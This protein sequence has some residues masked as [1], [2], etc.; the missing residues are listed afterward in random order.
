M[1]Q[2]DRDVLQHS[3]AILSSLIGKSNEAAVETLLLV[4]SA[5]AGEGGIAPDAICR[6]F[7]ALHKDMA[8]CHKPVKKPAPKPTKRAKKPAGLSQAAPTPLKIIK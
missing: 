2:L 1:K 8:A 6:R 5:I 3:L 7:K 4:L